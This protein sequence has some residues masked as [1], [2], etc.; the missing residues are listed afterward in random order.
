MSAYVV[1]NETISRI[2]VGLQYLQADRIVPDGRW[3]ADRFLD[4]LA[5]HPLSNVNLSDRGDLNR[6]G[7][8][9]IDLNMESVNQRYGENGTAVFRFVSVSVPGKHQLLK[10][11][12]CYLYQACEGDCNQRPLYMAMD[13]LSYDLALNIVERSEEY[14]RARW[15]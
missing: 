8:A 12:R 9:L 11:I 1:E 4:R 5:R 14:D 15:D 10:S 13:Q 3:I 7:Q 2:L 6:A